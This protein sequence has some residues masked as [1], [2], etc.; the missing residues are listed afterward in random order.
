[1]D[2]MK[3]KMVILLSVILIGV[4]FLFLTGLRVESKKI[5]QETTGTMTVTVKETGSYY[6]GT[7]TDFKTKN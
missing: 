5:S 4:L 1:M 7:N 6:L 2:K 3:K